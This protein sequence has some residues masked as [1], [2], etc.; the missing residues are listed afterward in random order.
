LPFPY[1]YLCWVCFYYVFSTSMRCSL[2]FIFSNSIFHCR[3]SQ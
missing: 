3:C 2:I 1:H